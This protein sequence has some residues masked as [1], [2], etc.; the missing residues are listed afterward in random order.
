MDPYPEPTRAAISGPATTPVFTALFFCAAAVVASILLWSRLDDAAFLLLYPAV[1]LAAL[2][3]GFLAGAA[4]GGV[5]AAAGYLLLTRSDSGPDATPAG[6][7][8][9]L[10]L[11]F[12]VLALLISAYASRLRRAGQIAAQQRDDSNQFAAKLHLQLML[13]EAEVERLRGELERE[14][15]RAP[16]EIIRP[17]LMARGDPAE[18]AGPSVAPAEPVVPENM[19][20]PIGPS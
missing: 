14:Q 18:F 6:S 10:C 1:A 12:L 15:A 19:P 9:L 11:A 8:A 17:V 7:V 16:V 5:E 2:R 20:R 13:A 4:T 3:G